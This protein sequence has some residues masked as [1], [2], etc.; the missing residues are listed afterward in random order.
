MFERTDDAAAGDHR[1]QPRGI[2]QSL[3]A[4][5]SPFAYLPRHQ[6]AKQLLRQACDRRPSGAQLGFECPPQL[7]EIVTARQ[8]GSVDASAVVKTR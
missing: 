2:E 4:V 6:H 1:R 3:I 7:F 5:E 8:H